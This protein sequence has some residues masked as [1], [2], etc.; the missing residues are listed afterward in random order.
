MRV[1]PQVVSREKNNNNSSSNNNNNSSRLDLRR[2]VHLT[3]G[4]AIPLGFPPPAPPRQEVRFSGSVAALLAPGTRPEHTHDGAKVCPPRATFPTTYAKALQLFPPHVATKSRGG[5]A[6]QSKAGT[7]QALPGLHLSQAPAS[8]AASPCP[9]RHEPGV[10]GAV[11]EQAPTE[12]ATEAPAPPLQSPGGPQPPSPLLSEADFGEAPRSPTP[13]A[14][15]EPPH[16]AQ[17]EEE[18]QEP[19][20]A[21]RPQE[22][23]E[24]R[25]GST[26]GPPLTRGEER[27]GGREPAGPRPRPE[28]RLVPSAAALEE[29]RAA[30]RRT[31]DRRRSAS[32]R[33]RAEERPREQPHTYVVDNDT[34]SNEEPQAARALAQAERPENRLR[35]RA[36]AKSK[37]GGATTQWSRVRSQ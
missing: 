10:S 25:P 13:R 29:E 20:P 8:P 35:A 9:R 5:G 30:E 17:E 2:P 7:R 22:D 4:P 19:T 28:C 34:D 11:A 14:D 26:G 23:F 37:P 1:P 18:E 31:A 21:P 6:P 15:E 16:R 33:P 36:T 24:R 3:P 32:P 12:A 27:G